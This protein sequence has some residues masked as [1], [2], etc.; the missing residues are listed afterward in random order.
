MAK[1]QQLFS[2]CSYSGTPFCLFACSN[3]PH[4]PWNKGDASRY[5]PA[6]V[7]LPPYI[8]DT[9]VVR[10]NFSRYLAEITYYD[11][12]VGEILT[13]LDKYELQDD[14][15][16]MV[17]SEQGNS[18]PF[19]KWTCY[20]HG[21]QS[22]MIVRWPGKVKPGTVTDAMVEYTDVAPTFVEAAGGTPRGALDGKSFMQVL[23]G[24]S[25]QHKKFTFG[26]MTTRGI[27]NGSDSYPIRTVRD[28]QYRLIWNLNHQAK[29]TN[30]CTKA[31]FFQSMIEAAESGDARA[32]D[33]VDKYH[34][35]PEF[36]LYD[37]D[38]D[39]L[40]MNNLANNSEYAPVVKKLQSRLLD[41]MAAQ[42]DE[43]LETEL[44]ALLHQGKYKDM[45]RE[46]AV[47]AWRK[48]I[49]RSKK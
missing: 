48:K 14:T 10:E 31:G 30:A 9:P 36:E 19:A 32:K 37:C 21:L 33:L 42:G 7:K 15:L 25:D 44:D 27:I 46:E 26:E 13:L 4:S 5:P 40:E 34:Y 49:T 35:R 28:S 47:A 17:V 11:Q 8:V 3:E 18:F 39:P 1:V 24:K 45:S 22:A 16:V 12:Q 29:F 41:W 23:M 38:T 43:G 2:E 20:G 6:T